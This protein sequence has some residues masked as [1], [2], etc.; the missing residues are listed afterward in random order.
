MYQ[1]FVGNDGGASILQFGYRVLP[2]CNL[3]EA[4]LRS[5]IKIFLT[6]QN[7]RNRIIGLVEIRLKAVQGIPY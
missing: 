5:E 6:N 3:L 7:V 2:D 1:K 4:F